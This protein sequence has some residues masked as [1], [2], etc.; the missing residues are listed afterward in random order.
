[1]TVWQTENTEPELAVQ[2]E[3]ELRLTSHISRFLAGQG[4]FSV[5]EVSSFLRAD[6]SSIGD[7]FHLSGLE[8]AV[9]RIWDAIERQETII[10]YGDYDADGITGTALLVRVLKQLG[11]LSVR[12]HLPD[13]ESEGYGLSEISVQNLLENTD[14]DLLITVDCG[15]NSVEAS[16]I[17]AEAGV[18]LIVTD[19]HESSGELTRAFAHINPKLS[20]DNSL[21]MLAGVGVVFKLCHGIVKYGIHHKKIDQE[22]IDLRKYL[23]LAAIG[24][25]VDIVPLTGQNRVLVKYGMK[26]LQKTSYPGLKALLQISGIRDSDQISVSQLG[27]AIGPR[28]NAAGRLG[29]PETALELLMTNDVEVAEILATRLNSLNKKRKSI[30]DKIFNEV[31]SRIEAMF[32]LEKDFG[33]M[34]HDP[35]WHE[36]VIGIV[37]SRL[38]NTYCRPAAV[39][40]FDNDGNGRGSC[41]SVEGCNILNV[42]DSCSDLLE[43]FGGHNMAAGFSISLKNADKFAERFNEAIAKEVSNNNLEPTLKINGWL[44]LDDVN[45]QLIKEQNLLEPFGHGHPKPVWAI[46]GVQLTGNGCTTVGTN[47]L[48]FSVTDGNNY[49]EAIAFGMADNPVPEGRFDVAFVAEKNSFRGMDTIQL[50]VKDYR[51]TQPE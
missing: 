47:H 12:P 4:F 22:S 43:T 17:L 33:I 20:E 31:V 29:E 2:I 50:N 37:A 44:E 15:T 30:C 26:Y 13:R 39:A 36:G 41:R 24:T 10:V 25:V 28:L 40:T 14:P 48:K 7:P 21:R 5:E 45:E 49:K 3:R 46:K 34:V 11:A 23:D 6:L 18:D 42:L 1:M 9:A 35:E 8:K 32:N 51:A 16:K 27:Y 38:V 19:H